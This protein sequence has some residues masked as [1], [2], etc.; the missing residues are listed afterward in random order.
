[1]ITENTKAII[2][3]NLQSYVEKITQKSKGANQYVCPL[4]GS[5]KGKNK[6]GAFSLYDNGTKWKCF[7]CGEQGDIFDLIE[8][9]EHITDFR[10]Q[11]LK[12]GE[13]LGI[14][15]EEEQNQ[16]KSEQYT[17]INI[18]TPIYTQQ[19][20]EQGEN[21]KSFFLEANKHLKETDYLKKRGL[22]Q[23]IAD[24]FKLGFIKEWKHP[25]TPNAPLT[26]RLIIPTSKESYTARDTRENIPDSQIQYVKSKV[27]SVH[28]F[29]AKAL[30]KA[31]K[32]IFIVEGE[33]DALSIME[34]GGEA[35]GIG[36]VTMYKS[37][38][39]L[40]KV[41]RP[42]QLLLIGLDNDNSGQE[43]SKK[44]I[45][46]LDELELPYREVSIYGECKDANEALVKDREA[47]T[48]A[49]EDAEHILEEAEIA[50]RDEYLRTSTA[51]Y[52]QGFINNI[53]E[54]A[55]ASFIPTGF[56][57]L[58]KVLEGG[59]YEGLYILGAIT[60]L[61]KTT[62][63]LQIADQIAM[64]G[65]DVLIFSLEMARYELMAK[66]I[67]RHTIQTVLET[68]GNTSDAKTIR[69]I[70]NGDRYKNYSNAEI[71]LI[72]NAIQTYTSYANH[73]H[74]NEGMGDIGVKE[75]R[76][77][78]EK[79]IKYTH[80]TPVVI[81]DY[82]QIL[83][84]ADIR[85]TDKQNIDK[86]VLELKRMGRDFKTPIIAVSSFNRENYKEAVSMRAFKESGSIEYSCDVLIGLQLKG[87]GTKD[88]DE[89]EAKAKLPREIEL[90]ILKNRSGATGDKIDFEYYPM[91]NYFKEA[92]NEY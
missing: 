85:A 29:N 66:S 57:N 90:V 63:A 70:T 33:I 79:H 30:K 69:G 37:F 55:N 62:L 19:E 73:N 6:T 18:H 36:S 11:A 43:Y 40:V 26:P 4:C 91:F 74:I 49:V 83:A 9:V 60:S 8:K 71:E 88:Y 67:S 16:D 86:A 44:L 3:S 24:R 56:S 2:T 89:N 35:I 1:M 14:D 84:P 28:I 31:T 78:I 13:I 41:N 77:I 10:E 17:H 82:L 20:E 22:S 75:I 42:E 54:R 47:F 39:D 72:N 27:G 23:E 15:I 46:G 52:I 92:H 25:K 51:N 58:D 34:V 65:K 21:Y 53:A 5:G 61:G 7:K 32:P 87:A 50:E 76:A 64:S 68:G 38:L 81:V 59:L 45:Q 12:A 80:N 48:Q